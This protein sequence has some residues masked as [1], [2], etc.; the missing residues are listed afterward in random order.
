[1]VVA[2]FLGGGGAFLP[3]LIVIQKRAMAHLRLYPI[4]V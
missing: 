3:L 1:M 4:F 2:F